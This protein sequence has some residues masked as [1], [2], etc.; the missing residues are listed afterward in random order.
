MRKLTQRELNRALLAR[1]GL[2][3]RSATPLPRVLESMGG[4][5]AQYAPSIYIGLW[6]RSEGLAREDVT[7]ALEQRTIVQA[8]LMRITI[9]VVSARDFW[10]IALAVR[11]ARRPIWLRSRKGEF[12]EAGMVSAAAQV[13]AR[14]EEAGPLRRKEIEA[15]VGKGAAQGVGLWVDLVRVP[16]HGT[17][18]R[19]RAD[20]FGLA[21]A[22]LGPPPAEATA[23]AGTE[24]LVRRYLGAFG[25]AAPAQIADW[26]GLH[27]TALAPVL[28]GMK[29]RRFLGPDDEEL[30]DLPRAPLPA[31]DTPAPVRFLPTWDAALIGHA[32]RTGILP[33]EDR[34]KIFDSSYPQSFPTFLVDGQVAGKWRHENGRVE[35]DPF[36]KLD[37]STR[38]ELDAEG[39]KLAAFL[40]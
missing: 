22:W 14:M 25:P 18:E 3:E 23:A 34:G 26:A 12:T 40:A 29:L 36:R 6:S 9:H 15:L 27:P 7:R 5:Q 20:L 4:L 24:L 35:L 2:L 13:R 1:Q 21:D 38:R 39:E 30:V 31:A 10:P 19:R 28:D 37:A 8:T 33:G 16:P 32:R 17:W 11:E